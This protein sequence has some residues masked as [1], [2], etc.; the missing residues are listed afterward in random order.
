MAVV[1]LNIPASNA[2]GT[3]S[4]V[5]LLDPEKTF[6]VG[7]TFGDNEQIVVEGTADPTGVAGYDGI[8]SFSSPSSGLVMNPLLPTAPPIPLLIGQPVVSVV[9]FMRVRRTSPVQVTGANPTISVNGDSLAAK[10]FATLPV[11]TGNGVGAVLPVGA[12]GPNIQFTVDGTFGPGEII[13]VEASGD[14]TTFNPIAS[15]A[16]GKPALNVLRSRYLFMRV[17]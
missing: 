12:F 7:G 15:F 14:G 6:L 1:V 4:S 3:P 11:P 10:N 5:A 8:A 9:A 2:T 16:S 17:R 13:T